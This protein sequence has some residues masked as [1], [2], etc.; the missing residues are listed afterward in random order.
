MEERETQSW[1]TSVKLPPCV[2]L[3][4]SHRPSQLGNSEAYPSFPFTL[5]SCHSFSPL[6]IQPSVLFP[7]SLNSEGANYSRTPFS[8]LPINRCCSWNIWR[9]Q[10]YDSNVSFKAATQDVLGCVLKSNA[11]HVKLLRC[12]LYSHARVPPNTPS[13]NWSLD[14]VGYPDSTSHW[15]GG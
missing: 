9:K 15:S 3:M 4:L 14:S 12:T 10:G 2:E 6:G 5:W 8:H 1:V 13:V 7:F 11:Q